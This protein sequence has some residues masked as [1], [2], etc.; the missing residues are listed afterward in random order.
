MRTY[1][2][3]LAALCLL[4]TLAA[5]GNPDNQDNLS[6]C[7]ANLRQLGSVLDTWAMDHQ[8]HY[9]E[10]LEE[11]VPNYVKDEKLL[12][13]PAAGVNTYFAGYKRTIGVA[14]APDT[15]VICCSGAN[16]GR[17][18]L[19]PDFPQFSSDGGLRVR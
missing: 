10:R 14:G 1:P 17:Q 3:F 19:A 18:D 8:G 7:G 15:Y 4:L 2:R 5:C 11:L 12:V 9:P 6:G 16:H 13:C